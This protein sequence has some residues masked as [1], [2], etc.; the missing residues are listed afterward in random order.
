MIGQIMESGWPDIV[1]RMGTFVLCRLFR[2]MDDFQ[3][4]SPN[5]SLS[6]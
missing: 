3:V 4:S 1:E 5:E 2:D 6:R